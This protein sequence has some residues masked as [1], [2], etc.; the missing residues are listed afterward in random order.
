MTTKKQDNPPPAFRVFVSS[1]YT[2]MLPYREAIRTAIN[3]ADCIPY[4]MERFGATSV[5]PIETCYEELASS[6]IYICA[7]GMRYGSID[8]TSQKSY[9]QLEYEKAKELGLPILAFLVDE[10][11]VEFKAKDIDRGEGGVKL[12]QFKR[13]IK[14]SKE[15]TCSFFDSPMS[16]QESVYRSILGEIKRQGAHPKSLDSKDT[17]YLEGAKLFS[18][19]V[20][21]PERYKNSECILR[22][23]MDGLYGGWRLRDEVFA[24]FGFVAGDALFLNDVYVTGMSKIDVAENIWHVDCFAAGE[25][26]DWLDDNFVTTGTLFEGKFKLVYELVEKGGGSRGTV[27]AVDTKIANIVLLKGI[28]V[29]GHDS[30]TRLSKNNKNVMG[31]DDLLT[32][33]LGR[34]LIAQNGEE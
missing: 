9:T 26:A 25:A 18:R 5:P 12:D 10:D 20:K 24:A 16:L 30:P 6:Q 3:K 15:V 4:G 34:L 33:G 2:D 8:E 31:L 14:D 29:I 28:K 17:D 32:S 27:G 13:E 19:F 23:R 22:V 11:K 7:I 21:R 1:T